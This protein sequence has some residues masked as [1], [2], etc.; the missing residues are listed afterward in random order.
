MKKIILTTEQVN[1]LIK[2]QKELKEKLLTKKLLK[3]SK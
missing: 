3:T 1:K 2:N